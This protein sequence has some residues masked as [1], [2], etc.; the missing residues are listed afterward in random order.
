MNLDLN[1]RIKDEVNKA[2]D[3]AEAIWSEVGNQMLLEKAT[4]MFSA[5]NKIPSQ[6]PGHP[7]VN[8]GKPE[9]A[10][11]IAFILDIRGS[12]KH[13]LIAIDAKASQLER[14]LYETAAV[15]AAGAIVIGHYKG[16]LTEYLGDGFL[17]LFKVEDESDPKEVYKAYDASQFFLK[18]ALSLVNDILFERYQLPKLKI[19]IGLAYS[20]AIVTIVGINNNLHPKAI[21]ECIFR[22]SRLSGG[23]DEIHIDTKL[24]CLWPK[25]DNGSLKFIPTNRFKD[26]DGYLIRRN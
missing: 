5:G 1:K 4:R 20:K 11:F 10:D 26:I 8:Q 15:N 18:E 22:A 2:L 6:I 21:G 14:V 12:T 17:A 13:L 16:G 24:K 9:V 7:F 25:S 3:N 23:Y 19:G